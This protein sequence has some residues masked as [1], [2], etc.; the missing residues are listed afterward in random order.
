MDK[1]PNIHLG[2]VLKEEFLDALGMRKC[3]PG[4]F[5]F[6]PFLKMDIP[7]S[8]SKCHSSLAHFFRL[9]SGSALKRQDERQTWS[10]YSRQH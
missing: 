1:L 4:P 9:R 3:G 2:E 8:L 5:F 7:K 6:F 10:N